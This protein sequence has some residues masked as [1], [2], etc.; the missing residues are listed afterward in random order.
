S[1]YLAGRRALNEASYAQ[2]ARL[3]ERVI[4]RHPRSSSAPDAFYW[5]ALARQ[6]AGGRSNLEEAER[7]LRRQ[8]ELHANAR[9][10]R[11]AEVLLTRIQGELARGGSASAA[12]NVTRSA[13]A[14]GQACGT[15]QDNELRLAALNAL[16]QMDSDRALPVLRQVLE[17]R[18][19]CSVELRR[20]AVFLVSQKRGADVEAVLLSAARNDPDAEVRS[21][22]VFWLSQVNTETAVTALDSILMG[23][24]DRE[25]Q[26]KAIFALS[27]QRSAR[28]GEILRR[29]IERADAP[30]EL[31]AQAIFWLGQRRS[32]ENVAYLKEIYPRL[33]SHELK[34]KVI[35]SI[36][37]MRGEESGRWLLE[38]ANNPNESMEL[39]KQALFWAGQKND[40]PVGGLVRLYDTINTRELQEQLI[41]VFSQ[42]R[43]AEAV[44]KLMAIA[45]TDGDE[46]LRKKALFWLGQ[47]KDPRIV[48][49]LLRLIN[50]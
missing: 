2:A 39:R 36:S 32:P 12:E 22:A 26:D 23:A 28:A 3:F 14:G 16:L 10:R 15:D 48:D 20:K 6:Q 40:F 31:K 30:D 37:Q 7:L 8:A 47:S 27:Q 43:E 21:Q 49:F 11:E 1:L 5:A 13:S 34:D 35:F 42:R 45:E 50:R 44:D 41:F 25:L 33:T 18:D 9:T 38:V 46:E 4:D 24:R 19:A 17:R 29:F